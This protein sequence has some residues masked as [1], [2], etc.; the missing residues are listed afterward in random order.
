LKFINFNNS[1]IYRWLNNFFY[2]HLRYSSL[3]KLQKNEWVHSMLQDKL[4]LWKIWYKSPWQTCNANSLV[5]ETCMIIM[6]LSAHPAETTASS[7]DYRQIK[8]LPCAQAIFTSCPGNFAFH[9]SPFTVHQRIRP[10]NK[11]THVKNACMLSTCLRLHLF[12]G[13]N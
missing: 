11:Y 4:M 12:K 5:W 6:G 7:W 3:I 13:I 2:L 8:A 9:R 1:E 10:L